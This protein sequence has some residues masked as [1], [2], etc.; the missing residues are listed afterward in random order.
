MKEPAES[1]VLFNNPKV[2]LTPHIA[3]STKE[4]QVNVAKM[5]SEQIGNYL[6]NK[7]QVNIVK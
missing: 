1:N 2:V 6:L 3:A 7:Q 4:A 5:I